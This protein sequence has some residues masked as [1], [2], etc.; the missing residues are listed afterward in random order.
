MRKHVPPKS[1]QHAVCS[2]LHLFAS[3]LDRRNLRQ[4]GRQ[5]ICLKGFDVHFDQA[6]KRTA[7]IRPFPAASIDD[8]PDGGDNPTVRSHNLDRFLH[9]ATARDHVFGHDESFVRPNLESPSQHQPA[10]F[11]LRE[12]VS[13]SQGA[14]D[15]LADD[16]SAQ[17][18]RNHPVTIDV[19]QFIREPGANIR[20][21]SGVLQEQSALKKLPA[22]QARPQN[23]MS[24]KERARLAEKRNQVVAHAGFGERTRLACWSRRPAAT[25][26]EIGPHLIDEAK[27]FAK[28]ETPSPAREER[29]LP[30]NAS[31]RLSLIPAPREKSFLT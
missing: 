26:F 10:R 30:T 8:H 14:P 22:V 21:D 9:P 27:K 11:F 17:G 2:V 12:N 16:D 23:E 29:A 28:A 19:P 6:D 18:G 7:K 25:H 13:F 15:F 5:I 20:R 1:S 31:A 4:I 24:I 3:G